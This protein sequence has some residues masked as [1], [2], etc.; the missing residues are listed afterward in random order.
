MRK[1]NR[2]FRN[3]YAGIP[4]FCESLTYSFSAGWNGGSRENGDMISDT[5][6]SDLFISRKKAEE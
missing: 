2:R 1:G 6:G 4:I 3:S 5:R